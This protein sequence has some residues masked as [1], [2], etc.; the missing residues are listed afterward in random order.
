MH[1]QACREMERTDTHLGVRKW[2][3]TDLSQFH[4]ALGDLNDIQN[5]LADISKDWRQSIDITES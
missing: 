3:R 5:S 2:A 1:H 4:Y